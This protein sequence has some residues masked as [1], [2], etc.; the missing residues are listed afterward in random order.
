MAVPALIGS[1]WA[2]GGHMR[3][4]ALWMLALLVLPALVW[5]GARYLAFRFRLADGELSLWSGVLRREHR[6]L[7]LARVQSVDVR[8]NALHRLFGVAELHIETAGGEV[9]EASLSVLDAVEA[10]RLRADLLA[11]RSSALREADP[12][13]LIARLSIGD[14]LLAGA[15]SNEAGVFAAVLVALLELAYQFRGSLALPGF[16][17]G[18]LVRERLTASPAVSIA[19]LAAAV[20]IGAWLLSIGGA[21][22]RYHRFTLERSGS[23][24]RKGYGWIGRREATIPLQRVQAVRVEESLLRRPLGLAALKIETA[25]SAPGRGHHRGVE[26]YLPLTRQADVSRVLTAVFRDLDYAALVLEPVDARARVRAFARYSAALVGSAAG[27]ALLGFGVAAWLLA[28]LPLAYVAARLHHRHLGYA[29]APGY[30]V[31]RAGF[32]N[33][34]TWI[35]PEGRIQT[36]HLG[37]TPFQRRLGLA[38]L[39]VDTAGGDAAVTDLARDAAETVLGRLTRRVRIG[40]APAGGG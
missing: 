25:G 14:R 35:I 27:L 32:L 17:Q 10:R 20:L 15:T 4:M 39:V 8:Q 18:T 37:E 24:L 22:V 5:G 1:A 29:L 36:M 23:E 38:S 30:A 33:R 3:M 26:A 6:V 7:P 16:E 21:L 40:H 13:R 2:G 31:L 34:I 11:R 12:P 28:L 19:A 9:P